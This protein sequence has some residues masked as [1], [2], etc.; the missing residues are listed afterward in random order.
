MPRFGPSSRTS[1]MHASLM[2]YKTMTGEQVVLRPEISHLAED[3]WHSP[4]NPLMS[5]DHVRGHCHASTVSKHLSALQSDRRHFGGF[6]DCLRR[7][8]LQ[9]SHPSVD[10]RLELLTRPTHGHHPHHRGPQ[11]SSRQRVDVVSLDVDVVKQH[12]KV[13]PG[14]ALKSL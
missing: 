9:G 8:S 1:R 4:K 3:P 5:M 11:D 7:L 14:E 10:L 12:L 13:G 2:N 6:H